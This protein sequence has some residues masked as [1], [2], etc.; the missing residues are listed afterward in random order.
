MISTFDLTPLGSL[1]SAGGLVF[2]R[3]NKWPYLSWCSLGISKRSFELSAES[4]QQHAQSTALAG[5]RWLTVGVLT[6]F[7]AYV[8]G[9]E[10]DYLFG[11][12]SDVMFHVVFVSTLKPSSPSPPYSRNQMRSPSSLVLSQEGG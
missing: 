5:A 9:A 7:I 2:L 8:H 12:W 3:H 10:G 6:L 4:R 1:V 11:P